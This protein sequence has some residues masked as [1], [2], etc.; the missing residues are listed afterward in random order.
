MQERE[1]GYYLSMEIN[2]MTVQILQFFTRQQDIQLRRGEITQAQYADR[3]AFFK[4][5]VKDNK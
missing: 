5:Q 2:T 1:R 4:K 3:I